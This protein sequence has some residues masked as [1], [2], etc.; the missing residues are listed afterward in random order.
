[1]TKSDSKRMG[2]VSAVACL[3]TLA[4]LATGCTRDPN[5]RKVK[6]LE[7]G[8]SYEKQGK[9]KEAII[10]FS[11]AVKID[12]HYA[13]AHFELAKAYL[14]LGSGMSA[15]TE[16]RRTVDQDPQNVEARIDLGHLLLSARQYPQCIE[17]AKAVLAIDPKNADAYSLLSGV[18]LAT[19]DHDAALK[20]IQQALAIDPNRGAFHAQLG[21]IQGSNPAQTH[22][23]EDQL[24][25]A[26]TL[27]P[28]NAPA[29]IVLASMLEKKGDI[30]GAIA[31]AQAAT[32]ADPKNLRA[33][34]VLGSLYYH[35]GDKA[36]AEATLKQATDALHDTTEGADLL[37]T[38][39]EQ[40]GQIDR[41]APVYEE[42]VKK[43]PKSVP[44]RM[45]YAH[46]LG[47]QGNYAKVQQIVDELNKTNGDDPQVQALTA[48]LMLRSGKVNEA[49]TLLQKA[50]KNAPDN[51]ALKF[52][53]G[54]TQ[55]AKG[56]IAGAE[57]TFR[58]IVRVNPGNLQAT[59]ELAMIA[60]QNHDFTLLNQLSQT[61]VSKYP[62]APDGYV[63][64]A[65]TELNGNNVAAA[66]GDFQ[67]ALKK[68]PN[69]VQSLL[70]LGQLRFKD[71]KYPEGMQYLQRALDTNP[72]L[73]PPLQ[74][75]VGYYLYQKQPEKAVELV[76]QQIAKSPRNSELLDQL[77]E[78]QLAT[79]DA[80]GAADTAQKAMQMNPGDGSAV[81]AYTRAAVAQGNVDAAISRW[82]GWTSAHPGD[83]N[84]QVILGN[85]LEA[86][87]NAN[88]AM[89]AYK[90]AL[91]IQPEQPVAANDLA[92]LMLQSGGDVDM[93]LSLA[94][95]ARRAMPH[96][97]NTA[98]T[99]A[100][101]YY[102]KGVYGSARDLLEDALKTAP[103]DASI[104]YHLGMTYSKLGNKADAI[105][106]LKKA[107]SLA[108][109]TQTGND[110]NKALSTIS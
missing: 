1:M 83:A 96:S 31:Q 6:Y 59:R 67:V 7:S 49:N 101:A 41:A 87:G 58:D 25:Q 44:I 107:A 4:M 74:M 11:N 94:Q 66:E 91:A 42:L 82:Q 21:M 39:Y 32:Q 81:M 24:R 78:L 88:G 68:N 106:H 20:N 3:T 45:S 108:P 46:V 53:L 34:M 80:A 62:D 72:N 104:E 95:T 9:D 33:W 14:K 110:A 77:A 40:T 79:K 48:M 105:S 60:A 26:V 10:Q 36:Q 19:G 70:A 35:K 12:P 8:K 5:V 22:E 109:N 98:D 43:Y 86:K 13:A 64:R 97:P 28:K 51:Q 93:A 92:F 15:F 69:D 55:K 71:K 100:W 52:W 76:R 29:H 75:M 18:A 17:Q 2:R 47:D 57:Q 23:A 54:E 38:Y 37:R 56:D 63:W 85:L 84:S 102:Q 90:K 73:I 50:S 30:D 61:M 27:D 16:L 65:M 99:L 103:N 89:D